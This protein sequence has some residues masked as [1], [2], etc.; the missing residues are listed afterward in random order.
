MGQTHETLQ[1][2][3]SLLRFFRRSDIRGRLVLSMVGLSLFSSVLIAAALGFLAQRTILDEVDR[4]LEGNREAIRGGLDDLTESLH[5]TAENHAGQPFLISLLGTSDLTRLK[6]FV[7]QLLEVAPVRSIAVYGPGGISLVSVSR[8]EPGVSYQSFLHPPAS[9]RAAAGG[10]AAGGWPWESAAHAEEFTFDLAPPADK[11]TPT[12]APAAAPAQASA[13]S[14]QEGDTTRSANLTTPAGPALSAESMERAMRGGGSRSYRPIPGVGVEITLLV[15]IGDTADPAGFLEEKILVGGDQIE[16]I[17]RRTGLLVFL[18]DAQGDVLSGS[19]AGVSHI[20]PGAEKTEIG[21]DPYRVSWVPIDDGSPVRVAGLLSM[22]EIRK[23]T[24]GFLGFALLVIIL[25][26]AISIAVSRRVSGGLLSP[27]HGLVTVAEEIS[28]GDLTRRVGSS[29]IDEFEQ[30]A[31]HFN[32]M[33]EGLQKIVQ[34]IRHCASQCSSASTQL[35]SSSEG[36]FRVAEQ[37]TRQAEDATSSITELSAS[38]QSVNK[39]VEEANQASV[40]AVAAAAQGE[41]AAEESMK[42]MGQAATTVDA[43]SEKIRELGESGK[44]IG[45]IVEVIT[46][47]AEQTSLL[48]L[49]AAI[50][51]ARAGEQGKGFAVVADEVSKLADRVGRSAKE[52]ESLIEAIREQTDDAVRVMLRGTEEVS[53]GRERV[54]EMGE[55]LA[56]IRSTI[57]H[58]SSLIAEASTALREQSQVAQGL[59]G[60]V[61]RIFSFSKDTS[62]TSQDTVA[63]ANE[64]A[65][66]AKTMEELVERFRIDSARTGRVA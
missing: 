3:K 52:I 61:Q 40:A 12:A 4:R 10:K 20:V 46:Q 17:A 25:A 58:A 19:I 53:R 56:Q 24:W 7:E 48:A 39:N 2:K 27:M 43:A 22:N 5:S 57:S 54:N 44:K 1:T 55:S 23:S 29:E 42:R 32:R 30:L 59:A 6:A 50:E 51:A 47:I 8:A 34:E 49:N 26:I 36:L 41:Q 45:T 38:I 63:H 33:G 28:R 37:G 65:G 66:I 18:V 62:S 21:K 35:L 16:R 9:G 13:V 64:L 14:T 31:D 60:S 11:S 15:P